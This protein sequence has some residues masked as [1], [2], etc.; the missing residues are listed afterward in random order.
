MKHPKKPTREQK[1]AIQNMGLNP[2]DWL[3]E[4]DTPEKMVLVHRYSDR[5]TKTI[6]KGENE[7]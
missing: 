5:T 2:A 6:H 4:R 7:K 1:K 3:V